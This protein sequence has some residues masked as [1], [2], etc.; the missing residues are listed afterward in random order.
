MTILVGYVPNPE[1]K[2]AV[3]RAISEARRS[4]EPL[5]IVNS[6]IEPVD[7]TGSVP[8]ETVK[9][10]LRNLLDPSGVPYTIR[11]LALGENAADVILSSAEEVGAS[12]I[13]IG[14]RKRSPIGKLILGSTTQRVLLEAEC[15]VTAVK[16]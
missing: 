2:A 6:A 14:V 5:L 10:E 13:V 12:L 15:P 4:E 8:V 11:Q 16:S 3:I 7:S 1:G 9:N